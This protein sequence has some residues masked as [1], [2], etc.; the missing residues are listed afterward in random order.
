MEDWAEIRRLH[1]SEH[2]AV[3]AISRRLGLARNAVRAALA[4]GSPP[5]YGRARGGSRPVTFEPAIRKLL[6]ELP[7]MP[8]TVIAERIGWE[9]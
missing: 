1:K 2:M 3:K 6:T 7:D 4:A 8:A 5:T 9:L